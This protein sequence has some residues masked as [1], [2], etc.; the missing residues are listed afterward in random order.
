MLQ[1]R[2]IICL[3]LFSV[4]LYSC[5]TDG[6]TDPNALNYNTDANTDDGSCILC[7]R[8]IFY[9]T[10]NMHSAC[11]QISSSGWDTSY[12]DFAMVIYA[13]SLNSCKVKINNYFNHNITVSHFVSENNILVPTYSSQT[14]GWITNYYNTIVVSGDTLYI[15]TSTVS[16]G[17]QTNYCDMIGIKQ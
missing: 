17:H 13:D 1:P 11:F 8:E 9:G 4:V 7:N 14:S 6:C 15:H 2:V 12:A 10:Y 3:V 5:R 16:D